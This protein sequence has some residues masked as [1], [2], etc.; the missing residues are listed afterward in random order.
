M[1]R[2]NAFQ[3]DPIS[4]ETH[5]NWFK[6]K[7]SDKNCYMYVAENKGV[8]VGQ[9]RFDINSGEAEIGYSIDSRFRGIG[10]GSKLLQIAI[11]AFTKECVRVYSFKAQVKGSN[12]A[13]NKIFQKMGFLVEEGTDVTIY[14][15]QL[16]LPGN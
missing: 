5:E 9:V 2:S 14:R 11:N 16:P 1:V 10:L 6:F 15:L 7:L 4:W 8:L 12:T 3:S 13:S